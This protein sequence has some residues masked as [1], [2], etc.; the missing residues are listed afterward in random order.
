MS[1]EIKAMGGFDSG[2]IITATRPQHLDPTG[3]LG[4]QSLVLTPAQSEALFHQLQHLY[5]C[6][7]VAA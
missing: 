4:Q 3:R 7:R 1:D 6:K 5:A 2:L